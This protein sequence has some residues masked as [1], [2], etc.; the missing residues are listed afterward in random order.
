MG[1]L[2]DLAARYAAEDA[3]K[4]GPVWAPLVGSSSN[5]TVTELRDNYEGSTTVSPP[6]SE[7][8]EAHVH[9]HVYITDAAAVTAAIADVTAAGCT[10][11]LDI[12]TAR[13][14]GFENDKQAGLDP[15]RSRIRLVQL[16]AGGTTYVIDMFAVPWTALA[17]LWGCSLVSHNA[18]FELKHLIH[19]GVDVD[20]I[21][22]T[23]LMANALGD[24][25]PSLADACQKHLGVEVSKDEQT[26]DWGAAVLTPEQ[27]TYAAED[28]RLV[29]RLHQ[30]LAEKL[31]H[32]K[33]RTRCYAFMRDSQRAVACMELAGFGFD[34]PAHHR[35]N[36]ELEREY[37]QKRLAATEQVGA[38]VNLN[39]APQ[40]AQWITQHL[41][42]A[43][44]SAWPRTK[45]EQLETG[46]DAL[47]QWQHPAADALCE[48][49][50]LAKQRSSFGD[51]LAQHCNPVTGRLHGSFRLA[52]ART[53]RMACSKPNLQ[54]AP[55]SPVFRRLFTAPPGRRLVVADFGQIELRVA[56]A[57]SGDERMLA[58]YANGED[59]HR[60]TAAALVEIEPAA[61]TPEQRQRAKAVNFG[62]LFGQGSAGLCDYARSN[63][64]VELTLAEA[65]QYR[66][67]FL[68]TYKQLA[69]WQKATA[70]EAQRRLRSVTVGGRIRD[71]RAEGDMRPYTKSLNTPVQGAAGE[72]LM[73]A[74]TLL[75]AEL[76]DLDAA[77]VNVIHDELVV[78][79]T[80]D[81]T[82]D[83]TAL[84]EHCMTAAWLRLFPNYPTLTRGI[85][86]A[87]AGANWAEAKG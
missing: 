79:C 31:A 17:G 52:G 57:L 13:L 64:G 51:S 5:S 10:I 62:L 27:L 26:S 74:M 80:E 53:G 14:P 38:G 83:V 50:Q 82:A 32:S 58:A 24:G 8:A 66:S 41:T 9:Q 20:S 3:E 18:V 69:R 54:Q 85:V 78:E 45:T 1:A 75:E 49:K 36:E 43:E 33:H 68:Q 61:V 22:C 70:D 34:K 59:L 55:R 63:Y 47:A 21:E 6:L 4:R 19:V 2:A 46:A 40:L 72:L 77:L 73:V 81:S 60:Q 7:P 16:H 29:W 44:L 35:W 76:R 12:E 30:R 25:L 28:A 67:T 84:L 39:S 65:E 42:K 37:E 56:A 15:H 71:Y 87:H 86:E 23:M 48:Y 11:G